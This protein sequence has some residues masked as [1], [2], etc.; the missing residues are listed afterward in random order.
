MSVADVF[1]YYIAIPFLYIWVGV[2]PLPQTFVRSIL[3]LYMNCIYLM[4]TIAMSCDTHLLLICT[5]YGKN[6]FLPFEHWI[7]D[8]T[9]V[10]YSN[11][12]SCISIRAYNA[13]SYT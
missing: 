8:T 13:G 9:I 12:Q 1:Y 7:S 5:V 4:V 10:N 6:I 2:K 11:Y 3:I